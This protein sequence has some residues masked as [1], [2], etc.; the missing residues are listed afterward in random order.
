MKKILLYSS[1]LAFAFGGK[2]AFAKEEA[3]TVRPTEMKVQPYSDAATSIQLAENAKVEVLNRKGS[4]MQISASGTSGW[5]KMLSIRF[6]NRNPSA[7]KDGSDL[8]SL[9]NLATTGNSGSTVTTATRSFDDKQFKQ[10]TANPEALAHMQGFAVSKTDAE[11][12]SKLGK[13]QA[14]SLNY[15]SIAGEKP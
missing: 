7:G 3:F 1:M 14:H 5:I 11:K 12:F 9:Y 13:L 15:L 6:E 2:L 10:N 8:K 4:W